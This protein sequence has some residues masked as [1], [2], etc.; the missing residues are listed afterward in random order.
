M[1]VQIFIYIL[2]VLFHINSSQP[3]CKE[4]S[5]YCIKCNPLTNLCVK[6]EKDN[7]IPDEKGGCK[8]K[9][10][11]TNGKHYC[12]ECDKDE[13]L[14]EK[15]SEE[16]MPDKN[17]GCSYT[18]N[19]EYSYNGECFQCITDF[20][21]IGKKGGLK[22]CKSIYSDDFKNC[23][24]INYET[25]QCDECEE[26][27]FLNSIDSH[28]SKTKNCSISTFGICESCDEDFYLNK[29]DDL[30]LTKENQ[31]KL[32]KVTLD[33]EKCDKCDDG[34]YISED[35]YCTLSNYCAKADNLTGYCTECIS[36][37]YLIYGDVCT[38]EENCLEGDIDTGL[39]NLCKN[40][41]YLDT[42]D[43]KCKSNEYDEEFLHCIIANSN[44]CTKCESGYFLGEDKKCS[45]TEYCLESQ[46]GKCIECSNNYY[47]G[48]DSR[49]SS[50]NH[51]IYSNLYHDCLECDTN[52]YLNLEN[53]T[54]MLDDGIFKNCKL[55][56]DNGNKCH[57]CK[58][59]YYLSGSDNLCYDNTDTSNI[60]Y[61][62][63]FTDENGEKCMQCV[64]NY[65]LGIGD[66]LCSKNQGCIY[67]KNEN[68]CIK[69]TDGFC[70]DLSSGKCKENNMI[71]EEEEKIYFKCN[72]TN[73]EGT[74]CEECIDDYIVNENGLCFNNNNSTCE[75]Y[76]DDGI[77]IKCKDGYPGD[78]RSYCLN[79]L[80]GCVETL[81]E[82]CLR[83]DDILNFHN[84]TECSE[85]Y[86]IGANYYCVPENQ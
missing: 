56:N 74:K 59:N 9:E 86:K 36:D 26:G 31:F 32:C 13:K 38:K 20:I 73:E 18:S 80:F 14:C 50:V 19:C 23:K 44:E 49:C 77:C 30:C 6:C 43:R 37:Y 71:W 10:K 33:G 70:L 5:N 62:C 21:I 83:C 4:N 72:Y 51:C 40:N 34:V 82:N 41:Y 55:S 27:Y 66:Y 42:F 79:E 39:C 53:N 75:E 84:C 78:F 24:Y 48:L 85:G 81:G 64:D 76:N 46:G 69:C 47:L 3:L 57:L 1:F 8:G 12:T 67:S 25:G 65:F 11:C 28:C 22:I 45:F 7:L 58:D 63:L 15:C 2:F 60:F 52:Y 17:G 16:Y 54:C 35:G 68:E 61:K 29:K